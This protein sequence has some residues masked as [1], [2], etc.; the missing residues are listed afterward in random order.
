MG[1]AR[2]YQRFIEGFSSIA[3]PITQLTQKNA[4]YVWTDACESSFVE[5]KRRLTSAHVLTI[6]S[7]TCG[8]VVY[9]DA[10]HR[11]LG[12]VL[13][14]GCHVI[15]Y[16]SRQLKPHETRYPVHDLELAAIVFALNIWRHY[17]YGK[18]NAVA[19][20]LSRKLCNLSLSTMS[21]SRL[22]ENFCASCLYFETDMQSIRIFAIQAEPELLMRIKEAQ[23]FDQNIHSSVEKVRS[24]HLSEYQASDDG[25]LF[26]NNRIVVPHISELR[27]QILQEAHCNKFSV[28]PGDR[29]LY[30]DLKTQYWWKI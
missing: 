26:V 11:G 19:D 20:A 10:S 28:H 27:Q 2:Y 21:V 29:K 8:F 15:A 6:T 17:L 5:M 30:N 7:G 12:C 25:T 23:K 3:K 18:S 22:I 14:Q 24:G 4:P 16:A 13:T 9:C 1:L